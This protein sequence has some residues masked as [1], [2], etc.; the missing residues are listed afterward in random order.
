MT[1]PARPSAAALLAAL[2]LAACGGDPAQIR[3]QTAARLQEDLDKVA[4]AID[5]GQ[6]GRSVDAPLERLERDVGNLDDIDGRVQG[7]L[8]DGVDRLAELAQQECEDISAGQEAPETTEP[9]PTEP[10]T[11]EPATTEPETT[12]PTTTEPETT[13]EPKE[14][15]IKEPKAE[16]PTTPP[17]TPTTSPQPG[18]GGQEAPGNGADPLEK[19]ND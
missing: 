15:K 18:D 7:S 5:A 9:A 2:A 8:R 6:C 10:E 13:K 3:A 19:G 14:P 12:E 16:D 1:R 4:L 11:T 17:E